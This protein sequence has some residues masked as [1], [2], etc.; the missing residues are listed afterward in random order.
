[1]SNFSNHTE[2]LRI[3]KYCIFFTLSLRIKFTQ[4]KKKIP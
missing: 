2:I 4:N 3:N 1:M